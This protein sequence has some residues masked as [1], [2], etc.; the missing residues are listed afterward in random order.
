MNITVFTDELKLDVYESITHIKEWGCTQ[1]DF[2]KLINGKA[3]EDQSEAELVQLKQY[4]DDNNLTVACLESSLGKTH[5]PNDE[6][7][8]VEMKKL[9]GLIR[10]SEILNCKLVRAFHYYQPK[11]VDRGALATNRDL[12]NTVVDQFQPLAEKAQNAGLELAF[13][14]CGCHT[15]EIKKVIDEYYKRGINNCGMAWDMFHSFEEKPK[16]LRSF[17]LS[18]VPYTKI[19][20]VK[21]KRCIDLGDE[22]SIPYLEI[23]KMV[24][25]AGYRD[26]VSIETHNHDEALTDLEASNRLYRAVKAALVEGEIL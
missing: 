7:K 12:F 16:D 24:H 9:D 1:V 10:A 20:H 5:L 19:I 26:A 2:R 22:T 4:L 17:V 6:G 18:N 25:A 21:A 13:E 14:N 23:F 11:P 8:A 3:I 15:Y